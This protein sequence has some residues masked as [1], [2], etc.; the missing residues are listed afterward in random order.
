MT[1]RTRADSPQPGHDHNGDDH[2]DA[3]DH[4]DHGHDDHGH[5]HGGHDHAHG[6]SGHVHVP[7]DFGR[8]FALGAAVNVLFVLVEAGYGFFAGSMAL[9]ADAGHN[10]SDV[11]GLLM[12]WGASS[13]G[14]RRPTEQFTYGFGSTTILAALTNAV[15]LLVAVGAIIWEALQRFHT[16][17]TV[18]AHTVM[19]VA[20][21]GI[22]INA[23]TA[24]LFTA[25]QKDDINVR[26]AYLHMLADAAVSFG[27]VLTGAAIL[28]TG[29]QWLD[30]LISIAIAVVIIAGTWGLLKDSANLAIQGVPGGIDIRKVR[31]ALT[32]LPG[33][34]DVHDLHIWPISTTSTALT[35]HLVMPEGHP[36]DRFICEASEMLDTRFSIRHT[37]VQIERGDGSALCRIDCGCARMA[38]QEPSEK[39]EQA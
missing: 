23:F 14:K 33:V 1:V 25:G 12:A 7:A 9:L 27:V 13:L 37:T 8:A 18:D 11:A 29:W 15:L 10:L 20:A 2:D 4:D 39:R 32:S 38:V 34:S 30:P 28:W 5:D 6:A 35:V 17:Q 21:L 19:W 26:G 22:L 3:H 31:G 36:G 16:P 24:Y